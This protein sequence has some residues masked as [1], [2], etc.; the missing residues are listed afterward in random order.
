MTVT[1]EDVDDVTAGLTVR[2]YGAWTTTTSTQ[3]G[4]TA[5]AVADPSN[6]LPGGTYY[7]IVGSNNG[8]DSER[9]NLT[10]ELDDYSGM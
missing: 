10:I 5:V 3:S 9:Y 6:D 7:I 1:V 8:Y 2:I 4:N